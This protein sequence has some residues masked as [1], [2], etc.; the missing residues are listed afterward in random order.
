MIKCVNENCERNP[1]D[2]ISA[3]VVTVDGDFACSEECKREWEKQRD[4]FLENILPDERRTE[5]WLK[6][7]M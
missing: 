7:E 3:V 1:L 6:G 2:S 5:Q 4:Y